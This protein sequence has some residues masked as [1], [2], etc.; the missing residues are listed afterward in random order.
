ML[1]GW[2]RPKLRGRAQLDG[3]P[4]SAGR[5]GQLSGWPARETP[6]RLDTTDSLALGLV[7]WWPFNE[8]MKA[9]VLRD[10]SLNKNH[11]SM[12]SMG[13]AKPSGWGVNDGLRSSGGLWFDGAN[14][15]VSIPHIAALGITGDISV[16]QWHYPL[17]FAGYWEPIRK[18]V[19][20]H[21]QPFGITIEQTNGR[22]YGYR[23][24]GSSSR[25]G[26]SSNFEVVNQWNCGIYT[27]TG[28]SFVVYL[29]GVRATRTDATGSISDSGGALAIGGRTTVCCWFPGA[30][31]HTRIY[32]RVLTDTEAAR[33]YADPWAG[34]V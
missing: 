8:G 34:A 13:D 22:F 9:T 1:S 11:G 21:V 6:T 5:A 10:W 2:P 20:G 15:Y 25:Y 23:G 26:I 33:I 31:A 30:I 18:G 12:V 19:G 28:S 27:N 7:G 14:D 32:N 16:V 29:N 3:Y 24:N 17:N 4:V